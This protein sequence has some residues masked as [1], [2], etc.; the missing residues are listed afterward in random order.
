[1]T[2]FLIIG[3]IGFSLLVFTW[4]V[5]EMFDLGHDLAGIFGHEAGDAGL[6]LDGHID[7]GPSPFSSRVI[8]TFLT[9]FGGGG[10]IATTYGQSTGVSVLFGLAAGL[11]MGTA[12]WLFARMLWRQQS[13]STL[14][15]ASLV[16][17]R[18]RVVVGMDTATTGQVT[19]LV[20]GGTSTFL[21][22]SRGGAIP[23]GDNVEVFSTDGDTLIVHPAAQ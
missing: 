20:G 10:A 18:G 16:G 6:N 2:G 21:A 5:G 13:S 15:V 9:A 3:G 14:E 22:R 8:F 12:T 19:L 4:I 23:A 17:K 7:A 11:A 1:M